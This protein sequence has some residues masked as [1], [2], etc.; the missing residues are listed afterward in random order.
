MTYI[1][2]TGHPRQIRNLSCQFLWTLPLEVVPL[3]NQQSWPAR[4]SLL[5]LIFAESFDQHAFTVTRFDV[6]MDDR[7]HRPPAIS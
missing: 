2:Y 7:N 1:G 5:F 4:N 6:D 3:M